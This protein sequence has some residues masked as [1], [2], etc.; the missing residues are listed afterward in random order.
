MNRALSGHVRSLQKLLFDPFPPWISINELYKSLRMTAPFDPAQNAFDVAIREFRAALNDEEVY[1]QILQITSVEEVYN[2][3]DKLQEEQGNHGHLRHLSKIEPYLIRLG[4]YAA[5]IEQ[6]VQVKPDLL[7][8]I[9]APIKLLLQWASSLKQSFDAIVNTTADIGDLLPEFQEVIRLFSNN[10]HI[11][12]V[13]VLFF[14][15]ILDFYLISLK[16][17]R[18]PRMFP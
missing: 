17:F 1:N 11:K 2:A 9:W 16:F 6:F 8:L 4:E 5:V 14:K 7:S 10:P 18:L 13:L 3:T 12:D 15:D